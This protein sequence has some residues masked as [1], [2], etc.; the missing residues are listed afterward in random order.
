MLLASFIFIFLMIGFFASEKV[1][2]LCECGHNA[3][4]IK[5]SVKKGP[6][7]LVLHLKRFGGGKFVWKKEGSVVIRKKIELKEYGGALY[8]L[9]SIVNHWGKS[10]DK[11]YHA[12]TDT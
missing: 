11:G 3:G 12:I 4:E 2:L 5:K 6:E 10:V 7:C 9:K 8:I 1:E